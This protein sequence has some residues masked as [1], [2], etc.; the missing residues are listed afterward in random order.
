MA[1]RVAMARVAAAV[2]AYTLGQL[3]PFLGSGVPTASGVTVTE[4]TALNISAVWCAVQIIAGGIGALPLI[5]YRRTGENARERYTDHP[6]FRVLHDEPNP[7]MS[8]IMFWETIVQHALLWG[9]GY[10][11]IVRDAGGR[12][13]ALQ[14]ITPERVRIKR[15]EGS[16]SLYYEIQ[17]DYGQ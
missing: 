15:R 10:A 11:E 16:G 7:D 4:V 2:R 17:N 13:R 8:A 14:L 5:L 12:M 1:V 3:A 6:L 9:N